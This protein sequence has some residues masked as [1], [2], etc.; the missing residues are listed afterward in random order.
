MIKLPFQLHNHHH[1]QHQQQHHHHHVKEVQEIPVA[2]RAD[3]HPWRLLELHSPEEKQCLI[4]C[5]H[6]LY[7]LT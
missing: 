7:R 6:F 1:Q 2:G 5:Q 3:P 4:F